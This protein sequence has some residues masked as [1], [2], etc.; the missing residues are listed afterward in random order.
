MKMDEKKNIAFNF[1]DNWRRFS[2]SSLDNQKFEM[3]SNSLDQLIG[4][5]KIVGRT[6]LDIGCGSGIFAIAASLAGAKKVVGIDISKDSI[7]TSISNKKK[8]ASQNAIDFFHKSIFDDD[9]LRMG[10][11]DTVYSWG[12]LHHTGNMYKAIDI[13]SKLVAPHSLFVIAIYN[14]H[15]S[16]GFWKV[17]K[18]FYNAAPKFIQWP[19]IWIFYLI[20]AMAKLIVTR[21]NPFKKR[22]GMSF[23]YDIIDWIGGYPYEYAAKEEVMRHL[24][25]AGFKCIK[26]V[27]PP[28][29]TG[30]NEFVFLKA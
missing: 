18:R 23:Y 10:E 17:I 11:F 22:R 14:K 13:A 1:G 26:Y 8:F 27:K 6:F 2:E 30:C 12:V 20:I 21:K 15:W 19:M 29:P 28:I 7:E 4:R 5:E 9:I 24:E 16:C 25:K 3:A